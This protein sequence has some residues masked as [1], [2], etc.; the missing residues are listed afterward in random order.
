M[1]EKRLITA[2]DLYRMNWIA[3]LDVNP[4][5]GTV[6]YLVK[7]VNEKRTGYQSNIRYINKE[8]GDHQFTSGEQ[9][10]APAWSPDG[11]QLAFLRK[12]EGKMQI[13]CMPF[14]G[15][16]AVAITKAEHGVSSFAWSPDGKSFI[17]LAP[18]GGPVVEDQENKKDKADQVIVFDRTKP[19]ADGSGIWDGKRS[20][21]FTI[22]L[23]GGEAVQVTQ[24]NFDVDLFTVSPD[25]EDIL[26]A[27]NRPEDEAADAD[28]IMTT[29][30]FLVSREGGEYRRL[31][32]SDLEIYSATFSPDGLHIVFL[33]NDYSYSNATLTRLYKITTSGGP[34]KCLTSNLDLTIEN[35][36]IS[37]MR[38]G[39]FYKP[40]FSKDG[41]S[42]YTLASSE[43]SVQLYRFT[44]DG[45]G[46][47]EAITTGSREIFGFAMDPVND[48]FVYASADA[49]EPGDVYRFDMATHRESR[50]TYCNLELFEELKLS[51]PEE[52]WFKA[53]DGQK[54]HGWIM[55][56]IDKEEGKKYPTVLEIHGG[57]HAM[58]ANTFMHEFQLLAAQGYAVV[59]TNPRGSH[60]YGQI[61]VDA[62]RGDYGGRDYQDLME[63]TDEA[64]LRYD[65]IDEDQ[66]VVT[67]G[68]YGG[69][70]TNWIV[71]HTDRFK[72]AVTQRSISNWLSFYGVSDIGYFFTEME[73]NGNPWEHTTRLWKHSPIAY[74]HNVHT[75]LLIL[76]GEEDLRCPIEQG[77]Q[78]YTALKRL[79]RETQ[80]VRFPGSNHN[81]S[82]NGRPVLRV[83]R[84]NRIAGWFNHYLGR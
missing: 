1:A 20:H 11:S 15:G 39:G 7:R 2:E 49:S 42:V 18:V 24:G 76:H 72:A 81:L 69:F 53:S 77:E 16:E 65:Y 6:A 83:E 78:M 30:L 9:D 28:L 31:T 29:D 32:S 84:L 67:G 25:G 73:I 12:H 75:P 57:P 3:G 79:G 10:A 58:Y 40:V 62:C 34:A 82:R 70:M 46:E 50:L 8:G 44:V 13:F 23:S 61:F 66:W 45:S 71:G 27:A 54:I 51:E 21:L 5:N 64:A 56:P 19:K 26:F 14:S 60:G 63:A 48:G 4:A 68:S 17:Y 80:L 35:A 52:F 43:G 74:V 41:Q 47:Y 37:D 59:Y 36:G 55:A 38:S 33:A 22:S